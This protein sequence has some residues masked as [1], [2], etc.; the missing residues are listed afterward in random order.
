[1]IAIIEDTFAEAF[2]GLYC[3]L[4]ITAHDQ[5]TLKK[6]A[7]DATATPAAVIG[8]TE[9]GIEKWLPK[10]ETPDGRVGAIVQFWGNIDEQ[11]PFEKSVQQ[12]EKEVSYRI[13]QD[14]LVKPFTA[15][16]DAVP[17][18]AG[19]FD[20]LE[21]VG[22]CGDG[23]EWEEKRFGRQMIIVPV[24]VPDF[25]IERYIGYARG[26]SGGNFWYMCTTKKALFEAGKR[27]LEAI[28][29][30]EGVITPF[31]V[32]SAGSKTETNY[33]LIG[34]TTNHPYCP[35]LKKKLDKESLVPKGI[36]YVPEIVINGTSLGAV[37]RAMKVGIEA[38]S[39]VE[40]VMSV[41][42]GNYGGKLGKY[43]IFL[44]ELF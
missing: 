19:T 39:D 25:Q 27:A 32:C 33:P 2:D 24:M 15:L 37:K 18:A 6:A 9:G 44:R 3:R 5:K 43:K 11:R 14:V 36:K 42:A 23:H 1:M 10:N 40:G 34:P 7:E 28:N 12:L 16:F 21:R 20:M 26:I 30:V 41:S 8:R 13:R 29:D 38:T 4:I 35:S 22:H 31:D 17:K